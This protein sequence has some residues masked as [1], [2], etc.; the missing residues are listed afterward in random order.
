MKIEDILSQQ[1]REMRQDF[2]EQL[3]LKDELIKDLHDRLMSRDIQDLHSA[4]NP[5]QEVLTPEDDPYIDLMDVPDVVSQKD[6]EDTL[7][8]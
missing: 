8:G 6:I 2:K 5:S 3:A 7:N 4:K 1:I